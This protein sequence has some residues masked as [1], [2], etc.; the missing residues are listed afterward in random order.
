MYKLEIINCETEE[1]KELKFDS[2]E[3]A[4]LYRDYHIT[5]GTLSSCAKWVS[6]KDIKLEQ[7]QF[8]IDEK[9]ISSDGIMI[10]YYKITDGYKVRIYNESGVIT[11]KELWDNLRLIRNNKLKDTD[12]TQLPD[13]NLTIEEKK[14][15]RKYRDYLRGVTTLYNDSSVH[16][17]KVYSFE[18]W[19]KY[20]K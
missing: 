13:N 11:Y 8:I 16:S 17:A 15:F 12:W 18:D 5:F 1:K 14:E 2:F 10:K 7:K 3:L 9:Y 20:F 6:E 4:K 19:K